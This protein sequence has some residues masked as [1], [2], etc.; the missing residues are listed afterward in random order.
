MSVVVRQPVCGDSRWP[1]QGTCTALPGPLGFGEDPR[2]Q[3]P[4]RCSMNLCKTQGHGAGGGGRSSFHR[5][6]TRPQ[7]QGT[8]PLQIPQEV[9]PAGPLRYGP[10]P[11]GAMETAVCKLESIRAL[12]EG[13]CDNFWLL[14]LSSN[15]FRLDH[16]FS[17]L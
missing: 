5:R 2:R 6:G 1:P 14:S 9:C 10:Q 7:S 11:M 8:P 3:C 16:L 15:L 17:W 12:P 4:W 13:V